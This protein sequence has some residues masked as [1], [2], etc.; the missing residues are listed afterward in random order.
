MQSIKKVVF[1]GRG[2]NDYGQLGLGQKTKKVLTFTEIS[3]L[4]KYKIRAA[5]EGDWHSLFE[6]YE[7]KIF[8]VDTTN[9]DNSSSTAIHRKLFTHQ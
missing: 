8:A 9:I 2:F 1:F 7:G 4:N 5:Y 3:S 6:T